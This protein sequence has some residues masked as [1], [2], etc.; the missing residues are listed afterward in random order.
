MDKNIL[1]RVFAELESAPERLLPDNIGTLTWTSFLLWKANWS[2]FAKHVLFLCLA[3]YLKNTKDEEAI[4]TA[5][6]NIQRI[7]EKEGRPATIGKIREAA[8][9]GQIEIV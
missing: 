5:T 2:A 9:N 1:Q 4:R 8:I 6:E 7:Y 3:W